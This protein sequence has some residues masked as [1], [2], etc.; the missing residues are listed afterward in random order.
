MIKVDHLDSEFPR[1]KGESK[2][3]KRYASYLRRLL[4]ILSP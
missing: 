1:S 3:H 2:A 4:F